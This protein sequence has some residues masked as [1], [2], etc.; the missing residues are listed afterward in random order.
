MELESSA[1]DRAA[2]RQIG[3]NTSEADAS[4][5]CAQ[6]TMQRF[7]VLL[8]VATG[9]ASAAPSPPSLIANLGA[10]TTIHL[11]G[12]WRVIIDPY[13]TGLGARYYE[14]RKPKDKQDLV[15][16]DFDSAGTLNVPGD[17]N[18]QRE[19]LLF[20]E[21]PVWYERS[22]SYHR[23]AA[24]RAF[25][26]F[27][28]ANYH[29]RVYLNGKPIGEHQ[30][31]FTPFN[32]E[33]TN[34]LREGENFVVVEVDN[35]R[36]SDAVPGLKTDWWNYGGLTRDVSIV[37]VPATFIQDYFVQLAQGSTDEIAGWV[38]LNGAT[39]PEQLTIGIPEA[40]F[41][42]RVTTDGNGYA[43]FRFAAKLQ[44][45]SP[46]NPKLYRVMLSGAG[47]RL[48]DQIGF[49]AVE[50]RG[51]KIL[52]N[53][54]PIFLRGISLHEEAAFRGGRAFS[55]EDD[56]VLLGWARELGC[57]F[58]RLAHYPHNEAMIRLADQMGLLVW[59]E[60][61]VYWDIDWKN[62][63][64]LQ[65]AE[66]QMRD[67]IARDQNRAATAFWSIGN[68][69]PLNPA[70][71]EFMKELVRYT[72]EQDS[73]RLITAAMNHTE[74]ATP[75]TRLLHDPLGEFLDVLGLNEYVGWYDGPIAATEALQ[76]TTAYDKPLIV[77]EFGAE[78]PF[79]AHGDGDT[80]WTEEY[81]TSL[82]RHQIAMLRKIPS[83]AG[84]S[85]WVLMDFRSPRR[86][87]TGV[88]DFY[89]RKGLISD[90]GQRKQAFF[91]LQEIYREMAAA[92]P[93]Q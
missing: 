71:L 15:E 4:S 16:Y 34:D 19:S 77:S 68:E 50:A 32:F 65:I 73:T 43:E 58:V 11:N 74:N 69:T 57:N 85:P 41:V 6:E 86:P 7:L 14:N 1:A 39:R 52:L 87:L 20:Y 10:R 78:T 18:S 55:A 47:D 9:L 22:F 30:G 13:E 80:R 8:F 36:H 75:N 72:R 81:Q 84:M 67:V 12:V 51:S 63:A 33:I 3:T 27:G 28:A 26:Y 79:G 92:P 59:E 70:R 48:E 90:R 29:A 44:L 88:Q 56:A 42:Q 54:K 2:L 82:Y 61:P 5:H 46:E 24:A 37:E 23:K 53:G 49:R 25:L 89:N 31:G 17:W 35:T 83:L 40:N 64:T 60:I 66:A 76:W 93:N 45:W 38:K 21:G 91:T 62:P